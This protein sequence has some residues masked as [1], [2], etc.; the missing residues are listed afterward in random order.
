MSSIARSYLATPSGTPAVSIVVPVLNEREALPGLIEE[1]EAACEAWAHT[2]IFV[3]DGSTDGT[4]HTPRDAGRGRPGRRPAAAGTSARRRRSRQASA[5][6]AATSSSPWTATARTT[7]RRSRRC[8]PSSTRA[9]TW[10]PGW[11]QRPPGPGPTPLCLEVLQPRDAGSRASTCTTSTAASRP[12]AASA[13]ARSLYGE[14]APL[15]PGARRAAAAGGS[16]RSRSTT[17]RGPT[18]AP[19]Y[20]IERYARGMLD[21]LSGRLHRPLPE[22]AAAPVRRD[23]DLLIRDRAADRHLPDDREDRRRVDRQPPAAAVRR[24]PDRGGHPA[25]HVRPAREMLV[26][27][28]HER[29]NGQER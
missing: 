17:G 19:S 1:I 15:H 29:R 12:T 8:W 22:P 14:P 16:P 7:R 10:S 6:P 27:I 23:R 9:S 3:D 25:L 4:A 28:R 20:G 11:K 13:S 26:A 18:A 24:A 21:L 2:R 5:R